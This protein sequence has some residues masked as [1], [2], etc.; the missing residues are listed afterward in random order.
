MDLKLE[1]IYQKKGIKYVFGVDE[2]GRGPLAGPVVAAA[3][4]INS[5]IPNQ[6]SKLKLKNQN[7]EYILKILKDS[8]GLSYKKRE[9]IFDLIKKISEI[10]YAYSSVNEKIIDKINI[11]QAT[12]LAMKRSIEKLKN[13]LKISPQIV[14]VDGNRK[15]SKLKYPQKTIIKG[16]IKVSSIALSSIIAKV[17]RDKKME[18]LSKK[19]PQYKFE[20]HKGYP[21]KLHLQL[22]K[23]YGPCKIHRKSY[24]PV[25]LS[26][27]QNA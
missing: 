1:K 17:I 12:F 18:K 22:L 11:E 20:I 5:K 19:Y 6:K 21:T 14:L 13:K 3:T 9:K 2:A 23:K 24:K 10:Q 25:Q 26:K 7:L 8:K 27:K 4:I 15:I 16:D